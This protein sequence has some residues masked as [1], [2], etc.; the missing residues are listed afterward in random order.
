MS[1]VIPRRAILL[2]AFTA[3]SVG[4]SGASA[5]SQQYFNGLIAGGYHLPNGPYSTSQHY[6]QAY[7]SSNTTT[8]PLVHVW[9]NNGSNYASFLRRG[10]VQWG[11]TSGNWTGTAHCGNDSSGT[12]SLT[13]TRQ[14]G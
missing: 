7:N 2:V 8:G 9:L 5:V 13:C 11:Y 3:L 1:H 4:A 6:N 14:Y 12:I 10:N